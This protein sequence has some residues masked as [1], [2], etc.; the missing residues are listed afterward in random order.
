MNA[1]DEYNVKT[2]RYL[3]DDL[4]GPELIDFRSNQGLR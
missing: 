1:C 4:Q 2:L 3:D